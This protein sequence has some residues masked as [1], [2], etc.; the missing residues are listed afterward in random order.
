MNRKSWACSVL[1]GGFLLCAGAV[2]A[3][4]TAPEAMPGPVMIQAGI[5]EEG[6]GAA[7]GFSFG[8]ELL[9]FGGLHGGK[10]VKGAPFSAVAVSESTQTLADGNHIAR[11]TQTNL[12]RDSEG[13][14]RKEVTLPAIGPLAAS[15][16]PH[17]LV[18][19]NDPVAGTN[20]VLEVEEKIARKLPAPGHME[21]IRTEGGPKGGSGNIG[22]RTFNAGSEASVKKESLGTQTIDGVSAEGT[23]YTRTIAVGEI[24]NEKAITVVSERWYSADLQI[25]VK[26]THS[27]PRFGET[28]YT[29]TNVQRQEP[30]AALFTV[31][32][33]Y[34][35]KEGGPGLH[36]RRFQG[37]AP[38]P[39]PSN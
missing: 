10:V 9:G 17:S 37:E 20:Y 1:S 21:N 39:P 30:A 12:Y 35:V 5:P 38:P 15:G 4:E 16:L 29:L 8:V 32:A 23:R 31:P 6:G 27:D 28:T 11:K 22:Y 25:E 26:S 33:D 18:M 3:Q 2:Q 14:F 13:R 7:G 36:V 34:T 19:I 24:G